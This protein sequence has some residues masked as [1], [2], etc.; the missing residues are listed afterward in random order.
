M[1]SWS[2]WTLLHPSSS[3]QSSSWEQGSEDHYQNNNNHLFFFILG[4]SYISPWH[5][6][7]AFMWKVTTALLPWLYS[8]GSKV[9]SNRPFDNW[10]ESPQ[11]EISFPS[12]LQQRCCLV[13]HGL[14]SIMAEA[15]PVMCALTRMVR[16]YPSPLTNSP[17]NHW[18]VT[19]PTPPRPEEKQGLNFTITLQSY[20]SKSCFVSGHQSVFSRCGKQTMQRMHNATK[21]P[22]QTKQWPMRLFEY[23]CHP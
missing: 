10:G 12:R 6:Q 11:A 7:P 4:Q 1:V 15:N 3:P 18:L 17:A 14:E 2:Y 13:P 22:P 8:Q 21:K 20:P 16:K 19:Q 5:S 23:L 9:R